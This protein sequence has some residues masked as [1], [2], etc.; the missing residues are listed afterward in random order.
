MIDLVRAG[1]LGNRV[2]WHD[3]VALRL[4]D[5][6]PIFLT[7]TFKKGAAHENEKHADDERCGASEVAL[8]PV[9]HTLVSKGRSPNHAFRGKS[10]I[11]AGCKPDES[12][13]LHPGKR[14]S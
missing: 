13:A 3:F 2:R 4:T 9:L 1:L 12:A 6:P 14:A 10:V 7:L 5:I 11:Q 8:K